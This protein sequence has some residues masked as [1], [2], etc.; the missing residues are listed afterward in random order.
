MMHDASFTTLDQV[1]NHYNLITAGN[2][3]LDAR[4]RRP[5]N[6]LQDLG[7]TQQQRNDLVAFLRTLSGTNVY[8]DPKW[9]NPFNA[10]GELELIILPPATLTVQ[11]HG[12]GTATISSTAAPGLAYEL[13]SS[14][15][16][17]AWTNL[18]AV[19]ANGDGALVRLVPLTPS[20]FYRFAYT[21]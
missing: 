4:F 6:R 20:T 15:N 11:N 21:P 18:G 17:N 8:T 3:D 16:L 1:V 14:T 13:Q 19:T 10:A 12:N 2:T 7:L 9:S 5:G